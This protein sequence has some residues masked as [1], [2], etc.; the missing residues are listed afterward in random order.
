MSMSKEHR[1]FV[2]KEISAAVME[3]DSEKASGPNGFSMDVLKKGQTF[4]KVDFMK[5]FNEFH[6]RGNLDWRIYNT[7]L[8]LVLQ[9]RDAF[10]VND[11]RCIS[12]STG[13]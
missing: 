5:V 12:E 2:E 13:K 7:F 1:P 11:F 8:A 9:E 3:C 6:N 4:T 10:R